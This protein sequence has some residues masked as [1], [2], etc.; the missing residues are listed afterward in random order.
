MLWETNPRKNMRLKYASLACGNQ[1]P[2]ENAS[3]THGYKL[4]CM[5]NAQI[6]LVT[7]IRMN[8]HSL[9]GHKHRPGVGTWW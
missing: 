2:L 3:K 1:D 5:Q 8:R 6:V 7:A 4:V 9:T